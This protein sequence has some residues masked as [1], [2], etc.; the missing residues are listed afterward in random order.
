[1]SRHL[2]TADGNSWTVGYDRPLQTYFAQVE[3]TPAPGQDYDDD[4]LREVAG[5]RP[6]EVR[7]AEDLVAILA[8]HNVTIPTDVMEQLRIEPHIP[9]RAAVHDA[10]QGL[11]TPRPGHHRPATPPPAADISHTPLER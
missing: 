6:G 9:A 1:M 10:R 4:L 3:P 11:S 2:F 8:T 7:T 5:E